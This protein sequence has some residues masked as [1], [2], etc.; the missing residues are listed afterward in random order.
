MSDEVKT[1]KILGTSLDAGTMNLV[2]ARKT[3]TGVDTKQMRDAF[4]NLPADSEKML[5]L[6]N[7]SYVKRADELLIL[8]NPAFEMA[9]V[10]GREVR[11][12]LAGGL[13]SSSDIDALGVLGLLIKNVLGPPKEDGEH[14]Y[15]SV[16]AAPVDKPGHDVVY[17][18]GVL[19]RIIRECGYTPTAGNEAMAIIFSETAKDGFSG[20]TISFGS[21]MT[22]CALAISTQEALSFSVARGGDWID[23]GASK[24]VGGTQARL[25]A[26]K[27]KGLNL[28]KP[29]GRE[30][31][32]ISFYYRNLIEYTIDQ[33]ALQF[34]AI[35]NRFS[36]PKPIP[37]VVSGGT[38]K[39]GGFLETFK[40]VFER[41][42]KKFPIEVSEIRGASD[43]LNAVAHGLLIQALQEY[44]EV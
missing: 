7:V 42:R 1:S 40:S 3:E 2:S 23:S 15:F 24:S 21:G 9:N 20:I 11:R 37:I 41:K 43:P 29:E 28:D 39:A 13:V 14:C 32:A 35:E 16:P 30:Q 44:A 5:R 31:E 8:G 6:S 10:F 12:P 33:I 25:C 4:L 18:Q 19:D 17:H 38:S 26:I 36:L 22:N 27:E 34:K